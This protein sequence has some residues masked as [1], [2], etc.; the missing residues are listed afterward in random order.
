MEQ[1]QTNNLTFF[2][3]SSGLN[4]E[5]NQLDNNN[6]TTNWLSESIQTLNHGWKRQVN[7]PYGSTHDD[8]DDD[9]DDDGEDDERSLQFI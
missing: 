4:V 1:Q 9:D 2:F 7:P 5:F 6:A 8:D 3:P